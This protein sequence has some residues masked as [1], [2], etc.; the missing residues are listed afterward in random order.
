MVRTAKMVIA[1]PLR[2]LTIRSPALSPRQVFTFREI[3][4]T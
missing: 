2:K 4:G 1:E 3:G